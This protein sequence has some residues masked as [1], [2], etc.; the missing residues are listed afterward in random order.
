MSDLLDTVIAAHG[1]L[2]RWRSATR[3]TA[4]VQ[5]GGALW[6]LKG[7]PG[8]L[9]R[10]SITAD[11]HRQSA[12]LAPFAEPG[13]RAAYTPDRVAI[14]SLDG[15]V[16]QERVQPRESFAGHTL[17]TPWDRVHAAYFAGYAMWT[18]LTEPFIFAEPGFTATEIEPWEE[19]GETWR[20]L[21]VTFPEHIATHSRVQTYYIDA[22][23]LIRRHDYRPDVFGAADRDSAHYTYEHRTFG[24][25][26]FPTKRSVH[27]TDEHNQK[28]AEP[29]IISID[30]TDITVS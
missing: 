27:L 14:E 24:G 6:G 4:E 22:E 7:Q 3:I 17:E 5:A 8:V 19:N 15:Q 29:V 26:V 23:G 21:E 13:L 28:V 30:L 1:G 18:Y 20:R 16:T 11:L 9:D 12:T 2:D 10:Y 25:L